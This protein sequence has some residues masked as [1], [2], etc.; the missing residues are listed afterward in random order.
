M[1]AT[2]TIYPYRK[3]WIEH[4]LLS[5]RVHGATVRTIWKTLFPYRR[6]RQGMVKA[7]FVREV[8]ER[9]DSNLEKFSDVEISRVIQQMTNDLDASGSTKAPVRDW[10]SVVDRDRRKQFTSDGR[11]ILDDSVQDDAK[12]DES[13]PVPPA[14]ISIDVQAEIDRA[15]EEFKAELIKQ[16]AKSMSSTTKMIN[17]VAFELMKARSDKLRKI[18][19]KKASG[20]VKVIEGTLPEVFDDIVA[21]AQARM[22]VMLVGPTGSGK[23]FLA[24]KVAE[25]LELPFGSSS[26]SEGMSESQLSG[27]LLPI[28]D[29]GTFHYV[30]AEFVRRYEQGGVYCLDEVDAADPNVMVFLNS[31]IA[32][33]RFFIP[34][35]YENPE[36]KKHVDFVLIAAGNTWG[37]GADAM[38]VG[39]NQLDEAT[40][41]RFVRLE[42]DY[43]ERVERAL[44][45]DAPWVYD[46]GLLVRQAIKANRMQRSLS[47]RNLEQ[48]VS[49]SVA[50]GWSIDK[51]NAVF[52]SGWTDDERRRLEQQGVFAFAPK[53]DSID[54]VVQ[55]ATD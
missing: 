54:E 38:F 12:V 14:P 17:D 16:A 46:W 41:N 15:L 13:T 7:D 23:S 6:A 53:S 42:V 25:V 5:R 22:N 43:N 50:C 33:D 21:L 2:A 27:W 44:T 29:S 45:A 19:V 37:T 34:Q 18:A 28:G 32:N 47:T 20:K 11:M 39:R 1:N 26:C 30:P 36:V 52:F 3:N 40:L 49:M 55:Q 10:S 31:A 35:R 51:I 8:M 9:F 48:V 4:R 24:S